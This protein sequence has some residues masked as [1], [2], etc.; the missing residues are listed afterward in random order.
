MSVLA[1]FAKGVYYFF[2]ED[3]SIVVG[4]L[5][6]LALVAFL[7]IAKPFGNAAAVAGPL[8][9]VLLA[10]LLVTNLLRVAQNARAGK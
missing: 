2:V 4:A 6:A 3:G 9:F 10:A 7:A 5:I 8:L 1:G